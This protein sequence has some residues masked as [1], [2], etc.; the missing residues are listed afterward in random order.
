MI[1]SQV[2]LRRVLNRTQNSVQNRARRITRAVAERTA[3][4]CGRV[5]IAIAYGLAAVM[6]VVGA[7]AAS[8][9]DLPVATETLRYESRGVI[10]DLFPG[11]ASARRESRMGF[12]TGG[13]VA[14]VGVDVGDQVAKG[15]VLAQLDAR[16]LN[17]QINAADASVK[18]AQAALKLALSTEGRQAELVAKG[19]VS[20][21]R[22]EEA[23][24]NASV[25]EA[26]V[27]AAR[28]QAN[29]LRVRRDLTRLVAP[30]D[31][32]VMARFL[33]EGAIAAPG[34]PL[35]ELAERQAVEIRVG[36]PLNQA[37]TLEVGAG[38][39]FEL[40]NGVAQGVLRAQT[41]MV[42]RTTQ[43]VAA[44]FDL[45]PDVDVSPGEVVRLVLPGVIE[46]SGF[47]APMSALTEGRR[48]LWALMAVVEDPDEAG[49]WRAETRVVDV[50]HTEVDRVYLR[51]AIE[52]GE[53]VVAAGVDRLV[54]GQR[55]RPVTATL[56]AN[57]AP[58]VTP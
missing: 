13:L 9:D 50:L 53:Q 6:T 27:E 17:A 23:Q 45:E 31:A 41:G 43:T 40:S 46:E 12:E 47:W 54:E 48:G 21:Q 52:D 51:G 56:A 32:V 1:W 16:S 2:H 33:D 18:E 26:R 20:A 8:A 25:A 22:L 57:D 24:A 42:D 39:T 44:V 5:R 28:A 49:V 36:V 55:V 10:R 3:A 30:F 38:Y 14:Q 4:V 35:L 11:L 19:H 15:D 29:L 34:A 37:V 58:N 7:M